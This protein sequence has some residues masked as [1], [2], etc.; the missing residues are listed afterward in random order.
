MRGIPRRNLSVGVQHSRVSWSIARL[1]TAS[2]TDCLSSPPRE[3]IPSPFACSQG[4]FGEHNL[5][6]RRLGQQYRTISPRLQLEPTRPLQHPKVLLCTNE[7]LC[8]FTLP[9]ELRKAR[10]KSGLHGVLQ[11]STATKRA[12]RLLQ[13]SSTNTRLY[14]L[15]SRP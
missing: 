5:L 7:R 4:L 14:R 8:H 13:T 15:A 1:A 2:P 9:F 11:A 12:T 10:G 3:L 6:P